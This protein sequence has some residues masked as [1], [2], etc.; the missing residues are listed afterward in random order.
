METIEEVVMNIIG[1]GGE[2]KS[3]SMRAIRK[4]SEGNIEEA[5]EYLEKASVTLLEAHNVQ[6]NLIQN[7]AKGNKTEISLLMVHAQDHLMSAITIKDMA[8]EFILV[9][10]KLQQK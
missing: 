10:E 3:Y 1:I 5:K 8:K 9:Y 2:A 7:E 4:A 6:T